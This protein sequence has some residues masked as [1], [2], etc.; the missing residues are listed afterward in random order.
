MDVAR[1]TKA[2]QAP[3]M[4]IINTIGGA[5]RRVYTDYP[6]PAEWSELERSII[7]DDNDF[8]FILMDA[9]H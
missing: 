3:N 9:L 7:I 4:A 1:H 2:V 6:E 5:T 8:V